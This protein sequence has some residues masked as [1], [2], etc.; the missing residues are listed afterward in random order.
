MATHDQADHV[1][2]IEE[3]LGAFPIHRLVYAAPGQD[4]LRDARAAGVR[5][6]P[7]AEGS[8]VGSGSLQLEALWP[9]R[10][11]VDD[12]PSDDPND[13]GLVL[14]ARWHDFSMLLS[15]DAEAEAA[16]LDPGPVD[17]LKVAHH[18]SD[19][20][21]LDALLDRAAPRLAVISVGAE[22][23][24]GHPTGQTIAILAE[25]RVKTLRTDEDGDVIIEATDQGWSYRSG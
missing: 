24:Y 22:N 10:D 15:A 25:H 2:G 7:I 20:A 11:F 1:G 14:L 23:P 3:L 5:A 19:D 16:P 8:E 12:P 17:V 4:Y 13:S 6:I 18:G 21:G 9:P